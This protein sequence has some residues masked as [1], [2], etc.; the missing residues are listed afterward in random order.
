ML[1]K[2]MIIGM[3]RTSIKIEVQFWRTLMAIAKERNICLTVLVNEIARA[4]PERTN[5]ASTLRTF[6]LK[7]LSDRSDAL[8]TT[9]DKL[10]ETI[11]IVALHQVIE[12][13]PAPSLLLDSERAIV[14]LSSAFCRAFKLDSEKTRGRRIEEVVK[15]R[16]ANS[17]K[18][19]AE[20]L[21]GN[22][23]QLTFYVRCLPAGGV[24]FSRATAVQLS[25]CSF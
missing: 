11:D 3:K 12:V 16:D 6:A 23:R 13:C 17:P 20:L 2:T 4:P 8:Q 10:A 24:G 18:S 7:Q 1:R 25:P 19:W 14:C 9:L 15:L 5:M 22:V 21:R